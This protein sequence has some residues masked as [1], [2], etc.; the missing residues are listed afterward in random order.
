[1]TYV[2]HTHFGVT[3]WQ[4]LSEYL[5]YTRLI[6]IFQLNSYVNHNFTTNLNSSAEIKDRFWQDKCTKHSKLYHR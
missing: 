5:H 4:M 2:A 6:N 1:M 3:I